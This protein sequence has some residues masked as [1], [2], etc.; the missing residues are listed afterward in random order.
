MP[1]WSHE[2]SSC[3]YGLDERVF[4]EFLDKFVIVFI[5]DILVFSKSK[6]EHEEH[7]RT[8]LQILRQEKLYAKFSKCEFWLSKVAFLGH[9]VS[10]EGIFL[11]FRRLKIRRGFLTISL[12]LI[13]LSEGL[14]SLMRTKSE[15]KSFEEQFEY[16]TE[17]WLE[18]LKDYDTNIQYH[19]GL[20]KCRMFSGSS[21]RNN[22]SRPRFRRRCY[23]GSQAYTFVECMKRDVATGLFVQVFKNVSQ[24]KI[25]NTK[26]NVES[27]EARCFLFVV[28]RL[29]KSAHF[30]PIVWSPSQGKKLKE[31][32]TR[33]KSYATD[34]AEPLEFQGP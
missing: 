10:A 26:C 13:K 30:L 2:C 4:H 12:T 33:Q 7:L 5:D 1:F 22:V 27:E 29:T 23:L 19:P 9:I 14:R 18:L 15:E 8:V 24:V 32:Q 17:T 6:E 31:A 28:D 20:S 34:I 3:I 25:R 11:W 16:E 21:L